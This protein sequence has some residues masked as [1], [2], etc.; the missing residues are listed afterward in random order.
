MATVRTTVRLFA[1]ARE[2]ARAGE[3][4]LDV[5]VDVQGH[6]TAAH[7]LAALAEAVPA[8]APLTASAMLA[9][10]ME[11]VRDRDAPFALRPRDEVALIPP[12][13]GG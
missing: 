10:N 1:G 12:V 2:A 9:V 13:S 7:V 6:T 8:L 4:T 5:P 11:Y 3:V